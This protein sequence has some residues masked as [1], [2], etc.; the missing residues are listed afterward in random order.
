MKRT[1]RIFSSLSFRVI[2]PGVLFM[3]VSGMILFIVLISVL[4][5]F[6]QTSI[7]NDMRGLARVIYGMGDNAIDEMIRK[8]TLSNIVAIKIK[9]AKTAGIISDFMREN[10]LMGVIIEN[11]EEIFHSEGTPE[12]Y[13]RY[14]SAP[15]NE[16]FARR[17]DEKNYYL[18]HIY[19]LLY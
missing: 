9:K 7:K 4:N 16:V 12:F 13:L 15:E 2:V 17:I 5:D 10:K 11:D 1:R 8:G 18:Y 19:L 3:L 14:L 6:V